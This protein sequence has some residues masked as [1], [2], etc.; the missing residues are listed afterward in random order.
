LSN[1]KGRPWVPLIAWLLVIFFFSTDNFSGANTSGIIQS[2][3]KFL[4]PFLTESQLY[5]WHGVCRKAG[6]VTEYFI[7]G[8]LAWRTFRVHSFTAASPRLFAAGLVLAVA[9]S[10]EFH[11]LFVPSRTG[12]LMDVGYDLA[13]GLIA[14]I[15]LPGSRN[16]ARALHSHPVL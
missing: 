8:C 11:Q 6:H 12:S 3:F 16:E 5:F 13:G 1:I 14:L 9:L 10:D 2:A 7:L 4:F 15:I